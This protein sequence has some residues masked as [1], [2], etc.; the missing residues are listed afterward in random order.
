MNSLFRYRPEVATALAPEFSVAD[1]QPDLTDFLEPVTGEVGMDG[2]PV[3]ADL[4]LIR[5]VIDEALDNQFS[6]R[7]PEGSDQARGHIAELDAW[8]APR[9]HYCLRI[10]RRLAADK[11][12]WA[13]VALSAGR[14]YID[15]RWRQYNPRIEK[16]VVWR[17]TGDH[18]R[19]GLSRLW[20][21]AEM[22]RS[23][24]SYEYVRPTFARVRTAQFVLELKYSMYR[25]APIAFVRVAEGLDGGAI[26][27]D[28]REMQPLSV[29]VNAYLSLISLEAMGLDEPDEK[30]DTDWWSR[31]PTLHETIAATVEGP[32][33]GYADP[34]A[35]ARLEQWFRM[36][37]EEVRGRSATDHAEEP[38]A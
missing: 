34:E 31:T 24:P 30:A 14:R 10:P 21:A 12:F 22:V 8:L 9:L 26:L 15:H 6:E 32:N 7:P 11:G 37:A 33:D 1:P 5:Q 13:Y 4:S 2:Q 35:V 28:E 29:V 25:P 17:Y 36:L 18:L 27:R 20:W 38:M 19:N 23:G 16:N 3:Q